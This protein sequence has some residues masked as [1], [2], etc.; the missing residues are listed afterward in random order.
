MLSFRAFFFYYA[1]QMRQ[2]LTKKAL[3]NQLR[4]NPHPIDKYRVNVPLSRLSLF[5]EIH[6]VSK[7]DKMYWEDVEAIW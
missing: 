2:Q 1:M 6:R 3:E 4:K 7:K 5:K